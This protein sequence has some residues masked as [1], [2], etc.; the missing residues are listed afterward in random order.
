MRAKWEFSKRFVLAQALCYYGLFFMLG[1]A[2]VALNAFDIGV[3]VMWFA[4]FAYGV[5]G[6][7]LV[8]FVAAAVASIRKRHSK[9][10]SD[11]TLVV[12]VL[13]NLPGLVIT[14]LVAVGLLAWA[15]K[16]GEIPT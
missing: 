4:C 8:P 13:V 9:H 16:L 10:L 6:W 14:V 12:S 2:A 1:V 7:I 11:R 5:M 15:S 3:I